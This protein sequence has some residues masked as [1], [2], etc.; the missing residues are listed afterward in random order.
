MEKHEKQNGLSGLVMYLS[1]NS[2]HQ[3]NFHI[4]VPLVVKIILNG[5]QESGYFSFTNVVLLF[6]QHMTCEDYGIN[7][8]YFHISRK[9]F[10]NVVVACNALNASREDNTELLCFLPFFFSKTS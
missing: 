9:Y 4:M 8:H 3:S 1:K 6:R 5:N 7:I 2:T 10:Q